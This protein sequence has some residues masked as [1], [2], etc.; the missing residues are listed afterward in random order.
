[1]NSSECLHLLYFCTISYTDLIYTQIDRC[2][3]F[4]EIENIISTT[5]KPTSAA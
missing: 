4:F 2:F 3:Q 1:M 5:H